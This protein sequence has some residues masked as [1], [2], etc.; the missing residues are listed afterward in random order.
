[1]KITKIN[2]MKIPELLDGLIDKAYS[3]GWFLWIIG[4]A[5]VLFL[6][7]MCVKLG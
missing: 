6:L 1:M 4:G 7:T 5:I 3:K 2:P